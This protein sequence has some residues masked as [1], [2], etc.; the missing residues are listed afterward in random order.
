M[1]YNGPS[2]SDYTNVHALNREFLRLVRTN[3]GCIDV[4]EPQ[5]ARLSGLGRQQTERLAK[6]P[7]LLFS[8]QEQDGLVWRQLLLGDRN[9]DLFEQAQATPAGISN[10]LTA[11]IGFMW[12]L[13]RRNGYAVRLLSGAGAD[14]CELVSALTYFDLVSRVAERRDLLTIRRSAKTDIWPKLL[15]AGVSPERPVRAAAHLAVLQ[16]LLTS[17]PDVAAGEW[18]RAACHSNSPHLKV[19]EGP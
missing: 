17:D 3:P 13:A 15:D 10:L 1:T 19:A 18:A 16:T 9:H 8:L 12:Q 2:T 11:A 14:W 4:D 6:T 5:Q 7:F